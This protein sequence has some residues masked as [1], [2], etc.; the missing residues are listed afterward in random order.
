ML[1]HTAPPLDIE[2]K[3]NVYKTYVPNFNLRPVSGGC[4]GD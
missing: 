1:F 4:D 3:I 2:L